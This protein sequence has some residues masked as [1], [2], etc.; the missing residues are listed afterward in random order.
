MM[1]SKFLCLL[2]VLVAYVLSQPFVP[3]ISM[4]KEYRVMFLDLRSVYQPIALI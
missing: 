3:S 1:Y 2:I 4:T